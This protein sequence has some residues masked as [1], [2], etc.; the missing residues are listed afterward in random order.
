MICAEAVSGGEYNNNSINE[1]FRLSLDI[2]PLPG[3][4]RPG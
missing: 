3:S 4:P 1:N 2:N